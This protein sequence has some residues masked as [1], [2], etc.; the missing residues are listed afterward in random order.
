[1]TVAAALQTKYGVC[2]PGE[3]RPNVFVYPAETLTNVTLTDSFVSISCWP[4]PCPSAEPASV[5]ASAWPP[6]FPSDAA[7]IVITATNAATTSR[8][9]AR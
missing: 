1:L 8:I 7:K 5:N 9:R 2:G 4:A 3:Y 6:P